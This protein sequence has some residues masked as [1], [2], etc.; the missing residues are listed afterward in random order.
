MENYK[1]TP[2]RLLNTKYQHELLAQKIIACWQNAG[3]KVVIIDGCFDIL[4]H[5]HFEY[6]QACK[7]LGDKL[8]VRVVEDKYIAE[9]KHPRGAVV[10]FKERI[11]AL[12]HLP[13]I[14][15]L[16]GGGEDGLAWI[17]NFKPDIVVKST[18]SGVRVMNELEELETLQ[19]QPEVIVFDQ[20]NNVVEPENVLEE[21]KWY[22][23]TKF[24]NDKFSGSVI[25]QEIQNR[26]Q[27]RIA[28]LLSCDI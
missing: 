9:S 8:V 22:D 5:R 27:E 15:L 23:E 11:L 24:T 12:T 1:P 28:K 16:T 6:L 13:Y 7:D 4:H 20:N 14:D 10:P 26:Y 17:D 21:A 18:T 19:H 2:E 25:K 3:H